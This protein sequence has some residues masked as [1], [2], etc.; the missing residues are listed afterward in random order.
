MT[1]EMQPRLS[2][3][4]PVQQAAPAVR[5]HGFRRELILA[6]ILIAAGALLLPIAIYFTGQVLLGP[7]SDEGHG[8]GRLYADIFGDL[9][10][11]FLPAWL[12][13]LSP[14]LGVQLLR[15]ALVP[16]R[17]KGEPSPR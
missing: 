9:A 12:L 13:V 17:R 6:G 2:D 11:G 4:P 7:Y 15:L 3:E 16:L 1:P 14:W 10:A 8:L 5:S